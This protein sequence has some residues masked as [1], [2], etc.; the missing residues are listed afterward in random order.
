MKNVPINL[1]ESNFYAF[2]HYKGIFLLIKYVHIEILFLKTSR[3]YQIIKKILE[4][5]INIE[6]P[7]KPDEMAIF[8]NL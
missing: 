7:L 6:H 5:Y 2:D 1:N 4:I 3:F 8:Q